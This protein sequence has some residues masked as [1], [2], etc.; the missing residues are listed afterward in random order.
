M[1]PHIL[2]GFFLKL[3]IIPDKTWTKL[4]QTEQ[5]T[6]CSQQPAKCSFDV[7]PVAV[8]CWTYCMF[9]LPGWLVTRLQVTS[10]AGERQQWGFNAH[11]DI[12]KR[13]L[14]GPWLTLLAKHTLLLHWLAV[15]CPRTQWPTRTEQDLKHQLCCHWATHSTSWAWHDIIHVKKKPSNFK[16]NQNKPQHKTL[17][18]DDWNP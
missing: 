4:W 11:C 1:S 14:P 16:E 7:Q 2:Y 5:L 10:L 17:L 18:L 12:T 9:L 3:V 13:W 6:R 15:S 8:C